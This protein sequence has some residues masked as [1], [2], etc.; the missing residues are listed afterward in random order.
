MAQ[1]WLQN[2]MVDWFPNPHPQAWMRQR[3]GGLP[4]D[5]GPVGE[6]EEVWGQT[7]E[8]WCLGA[9]PWGSVTSHT[10]H[11]SPSAPGHPAKPGRHS[12]NICWTNR[13]E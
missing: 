10:H 9:E 7:G 2:F 11:G 4:T 6:A 1:I 13:Q 3:A 8:V 5:F 12:A